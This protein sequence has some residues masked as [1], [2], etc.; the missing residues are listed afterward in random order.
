MRALLTVITLVAGC[1]AVPRAAVADDDSFGRSPDSQP[2]KKEI[3]SGVK[4]LARKIRLR[5][6]LVYQKPKRMCGP[7]CIEMVFRYWGEKRHHQYDIAW[8]ILHRFP[9]QKRVR[10]SGIL[11]DPE[12]DWKKYPGTGTSTMRRFLKQFAPTENKRIKSLSA[13]PAVTDATRREFFENLRRHLTSR[14]PVIVHQY[15]SGPGTPGH[16]R[17]VTGY[18]ESKRIIYLN[19][20]KKGRITQSYGRFL[21]L[22]NV[23]EPWLPYNSI[24]FNTLSGSQK[25][26][27]VR[28]DIKPAGAVTRGQPTRMAHEHGAYMRFVPPGAPRGLLV[29]VHGT[30]ARDEEAI[31][32]AE[33]FIERWIALA[34]RRRLVVLAPAF[35]QENYGGRA[36]P[37]GGYRGLFGR[38]VGAD[39]FVNAIV[40]ATREAFPTLPE[41]FH[42]YGHSAGGQFVSR[43]LV[44]HPDRVRAAVISAAGTFAFPNPDVSWT[45]GM[46]PLRRRMRWRDDKPWKHIEIVPAPKGWITAAQIPIAVVVGE[47][48]TKEIKEIPGNPG[49]THVDRARQWVR[50]MRALAREHGKT[51]RLRFI[52]VEN[53]GHNSKLL[54]P[55]CQKALF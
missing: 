11:D 19:D 48:D 39:V 51:P 15:T 17:V 6:P 8:A 10:Q 37:G 55:A 42:L 22:W 35:D 43:Y 41:K 1:L 20:P 18:D 26:K 27:P 28:I 54:T 34:T 4:S 25:P 23:D 21:E 32:A 38:L 2:A 5:V 13:D 7:A 29:L 50:A 36:G 52:E 33:T 49:R 44:M 16:Y 3:K 40:D 9:D 24:A 47:R 53:V 12:C 45:N 31:D 46:N 14:V 30:I